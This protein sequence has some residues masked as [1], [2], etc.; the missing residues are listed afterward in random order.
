MAKI[1][2]TVRSDAGDLGVH[3]KFGKLIPGATITIEEEEFGAG[4]FNR[5]APDYLSPHE[6]ADKA[7][8]AEEKQP[9][10]GF[11]PPEEPAKGK[12][13]KEVTDNA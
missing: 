11:G 3:H 13:Q 5:P 4:L 9:V 2:V 7:R 10:G 8:A 6:R 12:K 1:E